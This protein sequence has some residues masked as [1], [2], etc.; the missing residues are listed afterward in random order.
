MKE[1]RTERIEARIK[2]SLY[3]KVAK[4]IKA[5]DY[6]SES[7]CVEFGLTL[8]MKLPRRISEAELRKMLE[9]KIEPDGTA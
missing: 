6:R 3:K 1:Q 9:V 7:A 8:A 4:A 2:P 5:G